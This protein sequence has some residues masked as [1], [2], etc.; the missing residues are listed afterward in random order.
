[1][2]EDSYGDIRGIQRDKV[3]KNELTYGNDTTIVPLTEVALQNW[4]ARNLFRIIQW[5]Y[6]VL[7]IPETKGYLS[8]TKS[9]RCGHDLT[10][11]FHPAADA[12]GR[13]AV[14]RSRLK[15][16]HWVPRGLP[17]TSMSKPVPET[18]SAKTTD[19][20]TRPN[21]VKSTSH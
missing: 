16:I 5:N 14:W 12:R 6:L 13:S 2:Q 1:M 19:A 18:L 17:E 4:V 20:P 10:A 3:V 21:F 11:I 15:L 8:G 7:L 9:T